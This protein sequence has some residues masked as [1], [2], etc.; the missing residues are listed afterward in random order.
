MLKLCIY[1]SLSHSF[2]TVLPKDEVKTIAEETIFRS[3]F[4]MVSVCFTM[5]RRPRASIS[6]APRDKP[7]SRYIFCEMLMGLT[8]VKKKYSRVV[9]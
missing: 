9:T 4:D 6:E 3:E 5:A 8:S 7:Q 1:I 2:G